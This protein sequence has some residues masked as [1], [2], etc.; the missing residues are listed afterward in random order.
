LAESY[1]DTLAFL[2]GL[3]PRGIRL[4]LDRVAAALALRGDPHR[5]LVVVHVAGT[6]GKGSV[7][8]MI[9]R[10]LR[11]AG[12]RTGLYTSPHL[13]RFIE[14]IRIDGEPIAEAEVV[15]RASALRQQSGLPQLTFFEYATIMAF[16]AFR[17]AAVDVVVLE[18]GLGGRLD[19]T[20]VVD[21]AVVAI[22]NVR[23]EHQQYLGDRL[24][25]IAR[26]K[27]GVIK[28][29]IPALTTA[30]DPV[31]LEVIEAR[32]REVSAPLE[33]AGRDFAFAYDAS[34]A[35]RLERGG[36]SV[37]EL[38]VGLHGPWAED[39]A[40]LAAAA[41]VA[42]RETGVVIPD[43]AIRAGLSEAH[44]PGRFERIEGAPPFLID[45]AHNP[46]GCEAFARALASSRPPGKTVLLFGALEDKEHGAMLGAF[47]G[48]VDERVYA[49]PAIRRAPDPSV[50]AAVRPGRVAATVAEGVEAARLAAGPDGL[51]VVCGSIFLMAEVRARLLGLPE[52]PKIAL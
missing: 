46:A 2:Y 38:A 12:H 27:A 37:G 41:L 48:L 25:D 33:V 10:A 43:D 28:P 17:D 5:G 11:A 40:A 6:N 20:N 3:E 22:T 49:I 44:W 24:E 32:A 8:A 50:L 19:A 39:N 21:P 7:S 29:G 1:K 45:A 13:H 31:V 9:E 18:V 26:E 14:R 23:L 52:D 16:E 15:R 4:G 51:V 35:R 47:D 34:G 30:R 42:L 36:V